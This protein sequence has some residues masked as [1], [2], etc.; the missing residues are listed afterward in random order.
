MVEEEDVVVTE[1]EEEEGV[2][3]DM[4]VTTSGTHVKLVRNILTK[5]THGMSA[6]EILMYPTIVVKNDSMDAGTIQDMDPKEGMGVEEGFK[7]MSDKKTNST[8]NFNH[9][10]T[11]QAWLPEQ[12]TSGW[13]QSNE[14]N[15][16]G[17]GQ[18]TSAILV[19]S[20]WGQ[21]KNVVAIPVPVQD[22]TPTNQALVPYPPN[23]TCYM[24]YPP[25]SQSE[26]RMVRYQNYWTTANRNRGT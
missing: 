5:D 17:W 11:A 18:M 23:G 13:G 19:Q 15:Q 1:M 26:T 21:P 3:Q 7:I 20:G 4:V 10:P 16:G 9:I 22:N 8:V 24:P 14:S 6:S 12:R 25:D 2:L